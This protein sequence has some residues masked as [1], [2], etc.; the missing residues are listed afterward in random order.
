MEI[1]R[2]MTDFLRVKG[3][4]PS[5]RSFSGLRVAPEHNDLDVFELATTRNL[6][7]RG[8]YVSS[9]TIL[10]RYRSCCAEAADEGS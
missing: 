3:A 8:D 6:V 10:L 4:T 9:I 5:R 1:L 7:D 2:A